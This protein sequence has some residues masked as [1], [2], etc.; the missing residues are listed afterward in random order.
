MAELCDVYDVSGNKTGEVFFRGEALKKGQY[1]LAT[2]VWIINSNL[3]IL[4][5]KR[6]KLKRSYPDI[7]AV[8]GGCVSTGENSLDACIREA[9]EEIGIVIQPKD[10]KL[11]TRIVGEKVIMDNYIVLQEFDLS[12]AVL[13][14]EEVSGIKWASLHEVERM[15]K[16]KEFFQYTEMSYVIEFINNLN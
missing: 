4:I 11:L 6:S 14:V 3:E 7:W 12:S 13:Q 5:Q 16:K 2:N 9:Y 1:Q 10:M 15:L 8:H